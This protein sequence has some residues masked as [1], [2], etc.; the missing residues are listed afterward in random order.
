M[1]GMN[2]IMEKVNQRVMITKRM[3]KD[4]LL[5]ILESKNIDKINITEL[6]KEAGINRATFYTHYETPNDIL[7]EIERDIVLEIENKQQNISN[8][9]LQASTEIMCQYLY[10][11]AHTV[12][13]LLRNFTGEDLA[14]MIN[15]YYETI[16]NSSLASKL[17]ADTLKLITTYLTG[18]GFF[19]LAY[20]INE[21][22]PKNP[23]EIATL[24]TDLFTGHHSLPLHHV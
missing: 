9:S 18:G 21:E 5:R 4:A 24:I 16:I 3:L 17:D 19:L 7:N 20:W 13:I 11:N 6:C 1:K 14:K 10:Q 15:H 8:P 22:V 12:R 23:Q 2:I